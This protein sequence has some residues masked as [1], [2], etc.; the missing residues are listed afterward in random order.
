VDYDEKSSASDQNELI[1]QI[2]IT[3]LLIVIIILSVCLFKQCTKLNGVSQAPK[4]TRVPSTSATKLEPIPQN[5]TTQ[6]NT[7]IIDLDDAPESQIRTLGAAND[8]EVL[9]ATRKKQL[10]DIN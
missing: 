3:T 6:D 7:T 10:E 4:T 8:L 2:I 9:S 1:G 5:M